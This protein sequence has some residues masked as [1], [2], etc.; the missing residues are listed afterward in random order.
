LIQFL[1]AEDKI[2][3]L[4]YNNYYIINFFTANVGP[5]SD[6][7]KGKKANYGSGKE[8]LRFKANGEAQIEQ[9][10]HTKHAS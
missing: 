2:N 7:R 5:K 3:F 4:L 6:G 10:K 1:T 8:T 9:V